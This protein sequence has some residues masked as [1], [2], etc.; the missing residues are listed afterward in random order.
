MTLM[1]CK[2]QW[3]VNDNKFLILNYNAAYVFNLALST[4]IYSKKRKSKTQILQREHVPLHWTNQLAWNVNNREPS[5][6][7]L[8]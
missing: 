1:V 2:R 8:K 3:F 6:G 4:A 5:S 7:S